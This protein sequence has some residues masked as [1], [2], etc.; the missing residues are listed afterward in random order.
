VTEPWFKEYAEA[1]LKSLKSAFQ[2]GDKQALI[3]TIALCFEAEMP[4]PKW[5]RKEFLKACRGSPENWKGLFAKLPEQV[6]VPGPDGLAVLGP[7]KKRHFLPDLTRWVGEQRNANEPID[8]GLFERAGKKFGM[9]GGTAKRAYYDTIAEQV[10]K[11]SLRLY[12]IYISLLPSQK[13][14]EN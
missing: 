10:R 3:K 12:Y 7:D 8:E 13:S 11:E 5:A 1:N 14:A 9:S 2:K 6:L 4:V